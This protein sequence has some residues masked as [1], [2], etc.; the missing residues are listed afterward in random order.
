[1]EQ[2]LSAFVKADQVILASP[3]NIGF[4]SPLCKAIRDRMLPVVHPYLKMDGDRMGHANRY[5][6]LPDQK[7]VLDRTENIEHIYAVYGATADNRQCI[8]F[9]IDDKEEI[10]NAII[11]N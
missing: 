7:I 10:V 9:N 2:V 6:K 11:D 8:F 1:M 3:V 4:V 5:D